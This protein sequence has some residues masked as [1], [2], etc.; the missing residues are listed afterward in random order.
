MSNTNSQQSLRYRRFYQT[1]DLIT[2]NGQIKIVTFGVEYLKKKRKRNI[3]TF[4]VLN[5]RIDYSILH[6]IN[7]YKCIRINKRCNHYYHLRNNDF[8]QNKTKQYQTLL[9][10][11]ILITI[12]ETCAFKGILMFLNYAIFTHHIRTYY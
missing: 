9:L 3:F 1:L 4:H 12:N 2:T 6:C 8:A 7:N 10:L 11:K 5:T